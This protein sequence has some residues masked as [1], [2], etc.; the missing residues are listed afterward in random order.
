MAAAD[1]LVIV[2][3]VILHRLAEMYWRNSFLQYTPVC[4]LL[5]FLVPTAVDCSVWFTVAFT[6][7]RFVAIS[8]Q[9]LKTKYCTERTAWL[10]LVS[11]CAL[12]CSKNIPW[13]FAF[14]AYDVIVPNLPVGCV[15]SQ[16]FYYLPPWVAF[17][18]IEQLL[19]PVVPFCFIFL[20][21][22]YSSGQSGPQEPP[23]SHKWRESSGPGD[24]EPQAV[25]HF[26]P[27]NLE[28]IYDPLVIKS[29]LFHLL[30]KHRII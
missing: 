14:H 28:H 16:L 24:C 4:R 10:V 1:L 26:T 9:I 11:L 19:T 25:H 23:C 13:P 17:S 29:R 27:C 2:G 20:L 7:D 8:T 5:L 3:E 22:S 18:W 15:M 21:K 30:S 12:L 6:F